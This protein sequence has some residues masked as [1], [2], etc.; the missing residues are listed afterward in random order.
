[1]SQ[2]LR[3]FIYFLL[4]GVIVLALIRLIPFTFQPADW[5]LNVIEETTVTDL[6]TSQLTIMAQPDTITPIPPQGNE[7]KDTVIAHLH[8]FCPSQF[9]RQLDSLYK[10]LLTTSDSNENIRILHYGDSQIEGD[11]ITA[12]LREAF[13]SRF[14][15]G[16]PGLTTVFDP[17]HINPSVWID[18]QGDWQLFSIYNKSTRLDNKAYGLMGQTAT[19]KAFSKGAFKI[20][21]SRWA[22]KHASNYQKIR[23]F[24]APHTDTVHIKGH[25]RQVEV[26][27]DPLPPSDDLTEIN[28][29]FEQQSPSIR[30]ELFS[31]NDIHILACALDSLSGVSVDNI[32]LR[33][34]STPLL[35]RTN[36]DLFKAMGE[37]L[38][39]GLIIFQFGTNI[40]PTVA[41]NYH[42]Y[43]IQ[44]AKQ[45][46]LLRTYLPDVPVIVVGIADAAHLV[47]GEI[48][49]YEHLSRINEAQ[50]TVALRYNFAFFDLYNAM[51][52]S[53]S[54]IEWTNQKPPLALTDYIHFSRR[55]GEVAAGYLTKAL[56]SQFDQL[57]VPDTCLLT[58]KPTP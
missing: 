43:Q 6:D 34:Q 12:Y 29:E 9:I 30:F 47:N 55:G 35:H 19:L 22:E 2:Q 37:Q 40:I 26:I 44:L 38:N 45:F 53:G 7:V 24:L 36:G 18:S 3:I 20:N 54:I 11:R 16:G 27:N 33:G 39:I 57:Q 31:T 32:A 58:Q 28:W 1:M 51:G 23:L 5:Q 52:G 21:A 56:W 49:A 50:K 15:G 17:K 46:D 41:P 10:A 13:Q 8:L 48:L 25:I 14:G 42:F 4:I